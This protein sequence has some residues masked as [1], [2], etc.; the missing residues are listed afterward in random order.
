MKSYL[1]VEDILQRKHFEES[2]VVAGYEGLSRLVKW[3]HVVEVTNIRNLLNGNELILSTG[4]AWQ[5]KKEHFISLVKQLI[6]LQASGLCIEMGTYTTIIPEEVIEIANRAQFPIILI[7]KEV[8]FVDIT[9]DIHGLLINHQYKILSDLES[10]SLELSKKLLT[11]DHYNEVLKM[12]RNYLQVQVMIVFHKK[13]EVQCFPDVMEQEQRTLLQGV[14]REGDSLSHKTPYSIARLPIKLLGE[15]YAEL[16]IA[17]DE[18]ELTEFDHLILDRTATALAEL[19]LRDLYVEEKRRVEETKWVMS[20]LSGK[21]TEEGI[22]EHLA[23]HSSTVKPKGAFVCIVKLDSI[24]QN[25]SVQ[26]TYFKLAFRSIFDQQGFSMFAIEKANNII[27]ILVNERSPQTW[28]KR[29]KEGLTRLKASDVVRK[30]MNNKKPLFG[31]GKFVNKLSDIHKSYQS[32]EETLRIKDRLSEQSDSYFYEDL[33]VFRFI[34]LLS[35]TVDL[36]EVVD[37]YLAPVIEYDRKYNG[38][39]METLKTY[40]VCNGS[41]QETARQLFIVRQTLYHRLHK[42]EKLI[43]KDFMKHEKRL[44]LEFMLLSYEF[45]TTSKPIE[46]KDHDAL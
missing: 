15:T 39:L 14:K 32:A 4:V 10:Y 29:M 36:N 30:G 42:L 18:R 23:F 16:I 2:E 35:R 31:V 24:P 8:P 43:G 27:F 19:L 28:K 44:A 9:Q 12:I 11:I 17:S 26:L 21:E 37:E 6:A 25:M 40:L 1:T 45:L 33:H 13:E 38:K 46:E 7:H 34:S 3:V 41:K 22:Y 20:W 5:G